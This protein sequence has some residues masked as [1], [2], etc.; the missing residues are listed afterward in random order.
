MGS[1][2]KVILVGNM[3]KDA[4]VKYT[5]SGAACCTFSIVTTE[6]WTD[7]SGQKKEETEWHSCVLWGKTAETLGQYMTK[8][9]ALYL[10]GRLKTRQWEKDGQKRYAT[11]VNVDKVVLLGGKNMERAKTAISDDDIA[12]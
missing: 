7:K 10:E 11:E 8:G 6:K 9:K 3:G 5:P 4:E 1:V 2:N 12:F